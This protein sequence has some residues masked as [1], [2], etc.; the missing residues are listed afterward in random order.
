VPLGILAALALALVVVDF[1]PAGDVFTS[2]S[3]YFADDEKAA[4]AFLAEQPGEWR[5]WEPRGTLQGRY[6]SSYS[7]P[8]APVKRF[9]G[10][11]MEGLPVHT[12]ELLNGS[13]E[14]TALDLLSVRFAM[15][16]KDDPAYASLLRETEAAGFTAE[17]WDS[18]TVEIRE[19][20]GYRPF[21]VLRS[22]AASP[23]EASGA[24]TYLR[25]S[26]TRIRVE[27]A[28]ESRALLV[29]SE[30]WYPHWR[31][32]VDGKPMPLERVDTMLQGVWLEAGDHVAVFE[33]KEPLYIRVSRWISAIAG[34][35]LLAAAA[36]NPKPRRHL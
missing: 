8:L 7:L 20:S 15:L 32:Q 36:L 22:S 29:V 25:E 12:W 18:A 13:G 11:E 1:R 16:R 17:A 19:K 4:Y 6:V 33:Y 3:S 9:R 24:A 35:A 30:A 26:P 34:L 23:G 28:P 5:L 27:A 2:V 21:A 14:K 31:V 10:H